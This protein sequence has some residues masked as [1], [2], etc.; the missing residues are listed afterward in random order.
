MENQ[1]DKYY[2]DQCGK[3]IDGREM[4]GFIEGH[5]C[6]NCGY[7]ST[8]EDSLRIAWL[9]FLFIPFFVLLFWLVIRAY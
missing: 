1:L 8:D 7:K 6:F 3:A 4:C 2:C 5:V 9:M